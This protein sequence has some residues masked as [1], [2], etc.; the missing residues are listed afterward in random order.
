[1][2]AATG[3]DTVQLGACFDRGC[4]AWTRR[5]NTG[6]DVQF[7]FTDGSWGTVVVTP[8]EDFM[9]VFPGTLPHTVPIP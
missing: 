1:M 9:Q 8:E 3:R 7:G 4:L 5:R 2:R 6:L